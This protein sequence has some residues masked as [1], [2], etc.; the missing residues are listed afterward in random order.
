MACSFD[1]KQ[2]QKGN[3]GE[4]IPVTDQGAAASIM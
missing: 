4:V 3:D 1:I 2:Q